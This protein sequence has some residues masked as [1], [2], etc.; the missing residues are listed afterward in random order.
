MSS[1]EQKPHASVEA[2]LL[3]SSSSSSAAEQYIQDELQSRAVHIQMD[4]TD[5]QTQAAPT[6]TSAAPTVHPPGQQ[7]SPAVA[8]VKDFSPPPIPT[9]GWQEADQQILTATSAA[10]TVYPPGRQEPPAVSLAK[11]FSPPIPTAPGWQEAP[12]SIPEVHRATLEEGNKSQAESEVPSVLAQEFQ[13]ETS[14][15]QPIPAP[16]AK[17]SVIGTDQ[18]ERSARKR[19]KPGTPA[20]VK[21]PDYV[22]KFK[23]NGSQ[24]WD[25]KEI[26]VDTEWLEEL[27]D[28]HELF[29]GRVVELPWEKNGRAIGWKGVIVGMPAGRIE[30]G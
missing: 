26:T 12:P 3:Q 29:P 22:V 19:R 24:Q 27:Y 18:P 9:A 14:S 25:G 15:T 17:P 11:H 8:Q 21:C 16:A 28:K 4:I 23:G 6:A 10:P 20:T 7:E 13:G 2:G 5:Q 1:G 30:G